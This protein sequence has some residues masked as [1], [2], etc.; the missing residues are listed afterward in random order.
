MKEAELKKLRG[1]PDTHTV[2]HYIVY[3]GYS[4]PNIGGNDALW[5]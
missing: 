5:H 3:N 4:A 1:Q 2:D